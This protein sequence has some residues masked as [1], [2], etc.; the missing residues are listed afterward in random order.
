[1][2]MYGKMKEDRAIGGETLLRRNN[3]R[4]GKW[5]QRSVYQ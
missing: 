3:V 2:R 4:S 5:K 1:M